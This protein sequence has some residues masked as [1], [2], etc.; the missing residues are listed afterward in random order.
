MTADFMK[1]VDADRLLAIGSAVNVLV[2]LVYPLRFFLVCGR[3]VDTDE[4]KTGNRIGELFGSESFTSSGRN[5]SAA[6]VENREVKNDYQHD[7]DGDDEKEDIVIL[8]THLM[9][10]IKKLCECRS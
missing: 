9:T 3:L 6:S 4:F 1:L 7:G 2:R 10:M 5:I 8:V